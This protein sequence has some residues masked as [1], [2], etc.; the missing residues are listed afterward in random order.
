M[1]KKVFWTCTRC[2]AGF[3]KDRQPVAGHPP[4][5]ENQRDRSMGDHALGECH[6][7]QTRR[8]RW[9]LQITASRGVTRVGVAG[10]GWRTNRELDY[11]EIIR[12]T[13]RRAGLIR[14][15]RPHR[16]ALH[17]AFAGEHGIGHALCG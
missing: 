5:P 13:Q 16:G 9:H 6:P 8:V 4:T 1:P 12:D 3:E 10:I 14:Y 7:Q 15:P 11:H 17:V 2:P